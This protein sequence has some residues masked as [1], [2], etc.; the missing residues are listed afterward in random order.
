MAPINTVFIQGTVDRITE[1]P[2]RLE[3][4]LSYDDPDSRR[5]GF[6]F[7]DAP[8]GWSTAISEGDAVLFRGS[9]QFD[10]ANEFIRAHAF[11]RLAKDPP[12]ALLALRN[13]PLQLSP[14]SRFPGGIRL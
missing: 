1:T 13:S 4:L 6:F 3:I 7:I 5:W 8:L 9:L 10:G 11:L 14:G 2:S 12:D